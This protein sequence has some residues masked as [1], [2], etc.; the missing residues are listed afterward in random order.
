MCKVDGISEEP[1]LMQ[2]YNEPEI[3]KCHF[4]NLKYC[5]VEERKEHEDSNAGCI[6]WKHSNFL[7]LSN[8]NHN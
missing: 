2:T 6:F 1:D 3:L 4:C 8:L 7:L 5:L